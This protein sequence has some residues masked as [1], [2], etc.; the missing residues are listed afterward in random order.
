MNLFRYFIEVKIYLLV[1]IRNRILYFYTVLISKFSTQPL[2]LLNNLLRQIL[3]YYNGE[4]T[5]SRPAK[6]AEKYGL[7]V[8]CNLHVAYSS[9]LKGIY[10]HV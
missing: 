9:P 4:N 10:L 7:L 8:F 6:S 1:I 3:F 5:Y 2:I